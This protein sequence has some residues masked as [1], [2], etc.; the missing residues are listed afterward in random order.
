MVSEELFNITKVIETSSTNEVNE[1]L[2]QGW[3][4]IDRYTTTFSSETNDQVV[5]YVLGKSKD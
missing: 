5:M 2:S 1:F 4:L 3:Q